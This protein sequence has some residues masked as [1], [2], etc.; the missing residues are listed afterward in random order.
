[1]ADIDKYCTV[2]NLQPLHTFLLHWRMLEMVDLN[3]LEFLQHRWVAQSVT[4]SGTELST[5]RTLGE[6]R[7][8]Y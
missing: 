5:C 6:I 2:L 7:A 8:R 4:I 3:K 1:M